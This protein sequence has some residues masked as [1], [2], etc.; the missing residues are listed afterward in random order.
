MRYFKA[1]ALMGFFTAA[2]SGVLAQSFPSKPIRVVA[3]SP[4]GNAGDTAMRL[5]APGVS[6]ALGQPVLIENRPQGLGQPAMLAVKEAA[7]D[8]HTLLHGSVSNFTW[9]PYLSK[10]SRTET[11]RDF[12]AAAKLIDF[13]NLVTISSGVPANTLAELVEYAK[14]NPGKLAYGSTGLGAGWEFF[15]EALGV[16]M[17]NIPYA[18]QSVGQTVNDLA[19]DRIQALFYSY[20]SVAPVLNSGKVKV[21]AQISRARI[22]VLGNVP[23]VYETMPDFAIGPAWFALFAPA[24]TP[25]PILQRL[26]AEVSRALADSAVMAKL[27]AV[28]TT[29]ARGT[30]EEFAQEVRRDY[31]VFGRLAKRLNLQPM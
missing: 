30:L 27:E 12:V 18:G 2:A 4:T 28:G 3:T 11:M 14:R 17:V 15:P 21:L 19:T 7:P 29:P 9:T 1:M 16:S 26:N 8:G 13:P 6:A 31:E 5:V 23:T 25:P 10:E 22:R 20:A 24:G